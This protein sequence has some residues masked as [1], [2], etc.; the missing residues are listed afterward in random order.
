MDICLKNQS[1]KKICQTLE[2]LSSSRCAE[3]GKESNQKKFKDMLKLI[4][5]QLFNIEKKGN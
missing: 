3:M 2:I 5:F 1:F 4:I